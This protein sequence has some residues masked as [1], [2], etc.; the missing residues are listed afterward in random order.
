MLA[1]SVM[2]R[3]VI[4][5][6]DRAFCRKGLV[7]RLPRQV[8]PKCAIGVCSNEQFIKQH[9][10][11]NGNGTTKWMLFFIAISNEYFFLLVD[12]TKKHGMH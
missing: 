1:Y 7:P 6:T 5:R 12:L 2:T 3:L 10:E 8:C 9:M 4:E 11:W